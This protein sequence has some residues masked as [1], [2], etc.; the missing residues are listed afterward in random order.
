[1]STGWTDGMLYGLSLGTTSP[2]DISPLPP[3]APPLPAEAQIVS[4]SVVIIEHGTQIRDWRWLTDPGVEVP[5]DVTKIDGVTTK[6]AHEYGRSASEV[7]IRPA[8][9][10]AIEVTKQLKYAW[11]HGWPVVASNASYYLGVLHHE[12]IRHGIHRGLEEFTVI[13]PVIDPLVLD[14]YVDRTCEHYRLSLTEART[15]EAD[16]LLAFRQV[17]KSSSRFRCIHVMTLAELQTAQA[18]CYQESQL[19]LARYLRKT[20]APKICADAALLDA[21][22]RAAKF[23]ELFEVLTRA[24]YVDANADGWPLRTAS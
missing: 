24:D 20:I 11:D 10:V 6:H 16:T 19:S 9:E 13:G 1:M 3:E 4:A 7:A 17:W 12:L 22:E 15:T 8:S 5:A 18:D 21:D 14:K 23:A 2:G